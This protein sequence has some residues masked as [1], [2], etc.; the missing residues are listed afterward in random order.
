MDKTNQERKKIQAAIQIQREQKEKQHG[1]KPRLSTT[2]QAQKTTEERDEIIRNQSCAGVTGVAL[3]NPYRVA[4]KER[5]EALTQEAYLKSSRTHQEAMMSFYSDFI[6]MLGQRDDVKNMFNICTK[7]HFNLAYTVVCN[8]GT[9]K[10]N[11]SYL[12]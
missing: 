1:K 5:W 12:K 7:K 8:S 3:Q 11:A 10:T 4:D 9:A 6:G 2:S